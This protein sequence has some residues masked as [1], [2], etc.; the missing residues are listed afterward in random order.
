MGSSQGA[1]RCRL[2]GA[3]TDHRRTNYVNQGKNKLGTIH[4]RTIYI[5]PPHT[6]TH[7]HT[8]THQK[9]THIQKQQQ[10]NEKTGEFTTRQFI[11]TKNNKNLGQFT[12]GQFMLNNKNLGQFTTGQFILNKNKPGTVH[13]QTIYVN[14]QRVSLQRQCSVSK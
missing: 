8:H 3:R 1:T 14:A 12:A 9:H 6:H 2:E 11:L 13:H 10:T 7:T 5:N 4:H